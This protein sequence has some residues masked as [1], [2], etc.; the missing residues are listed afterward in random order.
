MLLVRITLITPCRN[1][2]RLLPA[3]L[4]SVAEQSDVKS[5]AVEIE[6]LVIDGAS[7]DDS[8]SVASRFPHVVFRS[9]PDAG[10]YD[11]LVK[12]L[13]CATGEI[14][15]YLNAGDILHPQ[16][17]SVL[18]EVF[19]RPKVHW[20]TGFSAL[21]N[22]RLQVIAAWKPPR[23]RQEFILN[24]TYL[25]GHPVPGIMQEATFWSRR[26][27][28]DFK[29]LRSFR[30]AGDYFLWCELARQTP[31]H[32]V[33]SLLGFFRVHQGQL[34]E[35]KQAYSDEIQSY[36][37]NPTR[38]ENLTAYWEFFCNPILRGPLFRWT[39]PPSAGRIFR[40]DSTSDGWKAT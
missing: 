26:L 12:G 3:T 21:V 34:S 29:T 20:V 32:A 10:M 33:E 36:L 16:A 35:S 27:E 7:E 18:R 24:G 6:H 9:E 25:R 5:G 13:E 11:A 37:R 38:R 39:L 14:V 2:A 19:T 40:Y 1:A 31:L 15:G 4:A 28:I 17:F 23:Y 22:D 30:L 8:R